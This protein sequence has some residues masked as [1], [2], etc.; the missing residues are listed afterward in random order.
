[1]RD[2][3]RVPTI[4]AMDDDDCDADDRPFTWPRFFVGVLAA[5]LSA[6]V[7]HFLFGTP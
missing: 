4:Q 6:I 3:S 5:A 1:M 7:T 2:H